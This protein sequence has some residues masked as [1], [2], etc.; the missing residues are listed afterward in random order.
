VLKFWVKL[1]IE[2]IAR[3]ACAC[4]KRAAPLNHKVRN[5]TVKGKSVI[6]RYSEWFL[7]VFHLAFSQGYNTDT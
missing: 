5:D 3:F 7:A 1:I 6:I 4:T 2:A